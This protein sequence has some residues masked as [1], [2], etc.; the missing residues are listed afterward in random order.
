MAVSAI[1][2]VKLLVPGVG[3]GPNIWYAS[4]SADH[5]AADASEWFED[6]ADIGMKVND[7]LFYL[8][9]DTSTVTIHGVLTVSTTNGNATISAA[10]LA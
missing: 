1:T 5:G 3:A 9:T 8:D 7:I 6:G 10:V 4:G 2:T